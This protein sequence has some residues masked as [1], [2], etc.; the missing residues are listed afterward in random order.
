MERTVLQAQQVLLWKKFCVG[1]IV[2]H[3]MIFQG[4]AFN[5]L[6]KNLW[7]IWE[8]LI[9]SLVCFQLSRPSIQNSAHP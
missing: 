6:K 4:I 1:K 7:G 8:R 5:I 2:C 3:K 9:K